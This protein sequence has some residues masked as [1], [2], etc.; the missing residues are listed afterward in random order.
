MRK[1]MMLLFWQ[2]RHRVCIVVHFHT[3]FVYKLGLQNGGYVGGRYTAW[4]MNFICAQDTSQQFHTT[5]IP[6]HYV[7]K[8]DVS[9]CMSLSVCVC[10]VRYLNLNIF[11]VQH[12]QATCLIGGK[13]SQQWWHRELMQAHMTCVYACVYIGTPDLVMFC[14]ALRAWLYALDSF[15]EKV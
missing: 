3:L 4:Y 13:Q 9:V 12:C 5:V 2:I 1:I 10:F 6:T 8:C 14:T 7:H 15:Q 11:L